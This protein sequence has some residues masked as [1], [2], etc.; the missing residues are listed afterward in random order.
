M[1]QWEKYAGEVSRVKGQRV[2]LPSYDK[3]L[4]STELVLDDQSQLREG[5]RVHGENDVRM[6]GRVIREGGERREKKRER[7]EKREGRKSNQQLARFTVDELVCTP[8]Q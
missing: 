5:N 3:V 2:T 4:I 8:H 1:K 6:G 7:S